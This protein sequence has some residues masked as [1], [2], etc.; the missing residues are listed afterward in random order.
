M[1]R[2][3]KAL[4]A[5]GII[6]VLAVLG[7]LSVRNAGGRGAE[8]RMED[9]EKRDLVAIVTANGNI[10]AR[11]KVDISADVMGR[12]VQLDVDEGDHVEEGAVL[13]RID[14]TQLQAAHA[15]TQAQLSQSRA[16]AAQQNANLLQAEREATRMES[17]W[18]RD[19]TLVSLQQVEDA[20][21][22]FE[23]ARSLLE[24]ANFGVEQ[25]QAA[26]REAADNLSKATIR[27]PMPGKVTR[28][29][30]EAGE[31]AVI[32]TMNNPGSLLLTISDLSV[33]EAVMEVDET[34]VPEISLGDSAVVELDAFPDIEFTGRVTE[35][36]N[37][38]IRP[39]SDNTAGQSQ[40]IDFEVVVTLVDPP[41]E[42]RP[43]LSAT[44]EIITERRDGVV[45]V[46][47]IAVTVRDPQGAQPEANESTGASNEDGVDGVFVVVGGVA[48]F[49]PV[50]LGIA[51]QDYF[52][53]IS[54]LE[55][56]E[57]VV[58]GPYQAVRTLTAG[59][60][61]VTEEGTDEEESG[62]S[63]VSVQVGSGS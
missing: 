8:V 6:V 56:G 53:I 27:A 12:I 21:T 44:A 51:G 31:M 49:R 18:A 26:V 42:L 3:R 54:G 28:L 43:D 29:N 30:V 20:R 35:I 61:V 50:E 14:P 46:P 25:A 1:S 32:G 9:V 57:T 2:G 47:I 63:S 19:S 52:E 24:S 11:R 40:T 5:V 10:R 41:V 58:A 17:L 37:S 7:G 45:S 36:G 23:V 48:E 16:G 4:I 13:L 62:S 38:A 22:G 39:P 59:D 60:P 33:V 34:D 15:R 55:V